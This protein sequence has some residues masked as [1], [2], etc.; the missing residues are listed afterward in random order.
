MSRKDDKEEEFE[1]HQFERD[2]DLDD[3][4]VSQV[5]IERFV[6]YR[7]P[8]LTEMKAEVGRGELLSDGEIEVLSRIV[9]RAGNFEHF[10]YEYPE[11]KELVAKVID[12]VDEIT[13]LA[14]E[15]AERDS[16]SA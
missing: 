7:L 8:M 16:G 15:N 6:K 9:T 5:I 3:T 4:G 12:L 10:V 2:E 11:L 1:P 14:V 13:D